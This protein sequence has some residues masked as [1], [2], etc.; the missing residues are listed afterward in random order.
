MKNIV[1]YLD[2]DCAFYSIYKGVAVVLTPNTQ[3]IA[4]WATE[5]KTFKKLKKWKLEEFDDKVVKAKIK[6]DE[7]QQR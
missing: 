7:D 5:F 3:Q 6:F 1:E 2:D 4:D